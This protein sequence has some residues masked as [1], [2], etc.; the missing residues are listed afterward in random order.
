MG[1]RS[2]GGAYEST[3]GRDR[4]G[5]GALDPDEA[6]DSRVGNEYYEE[7]ELGLQDPQQGPYG[8]SGYGNVVGAEVD[9][10][11]GRSK[12]RQRELDER[13]DEE[14]EVEGINSISNPFGD[15]AASSMRGVS[16]RPM[17]DTKGG[18]G[19]GHMTQNSLEPDESPNE[20]RSMFRENM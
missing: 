16:P 7:Q 1:G 11:R 10:G 3:T 15:D 14:M 8:G 20:R 13:Y 12:D 17:I 2:A 4:R 5:F 18:K 19:K 6:W 9:P